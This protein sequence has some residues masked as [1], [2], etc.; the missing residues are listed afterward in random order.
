MRLELAPLL[1]LSKS[2][3][4]PSDKPL[5]NDMVQ[6]GVTGI[7]IVKRYSPFGWSLPPIIT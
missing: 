5:R 1:P 2:Q 3:M 6:E 7:Y 4:G